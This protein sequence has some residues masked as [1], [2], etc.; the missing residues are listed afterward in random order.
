MDTILNIGAFLSTSKVN[1]PGTRSV[2]WS[3]GCR[4][5][6][7][8]CYNQAFRK[9]RIAKLYSVRSLYEMIMANR[10]EISG[11]TFSG[12]EPFDQARGLYELSRLLKQ[13]GLHIMSYSGYTLDE[14]K[15]DSDPFKRKLLDVLDILIDGPYMDDRKMFSEWRTSANQNVYYLNEEN[16]RKPSPHGEELEVIIDER[17]NLTITGTFADNILAR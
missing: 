12:G 11:V 13:K 1:G 10:N 15:S 17:G 16:M 8:G 6:C 3:Q 9:S 5:N 4:K 2:V 14:L 7:P